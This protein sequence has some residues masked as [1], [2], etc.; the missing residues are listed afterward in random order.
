MLMAPFLIMFLGFTWMSGNLHAEE[1]AASP[2]Q[3]DYAFYDAWNDRHFFDL[4]DGVETVTMFADRNGA[5]HRFPPGFKRLLQP[6]TD[7]R[8]AQPWLWNSPYVYAFRE[9]LSFIGEGPYIDWSQEEVDGG[10][11]INMAIDIT[12]TSSSSYMQGYKLPIQADVIREEV[13]KALSE[14]IGRHER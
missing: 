10:F 8:Y 3:L 1:Q 9:K 12:E 4:Y 13:R 5:W 14:R 11:S 2:Y 6:L 7:G